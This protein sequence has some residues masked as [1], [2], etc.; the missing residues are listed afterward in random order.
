[1]KELLLLPAKGLGC[2]GAAVSVELNVPSLL[3]NVPLSPL[4][5][6]NEGARAIVGVE[7]D[8]AG[9][10]VGGALP[11]EME[12]K[13]EASDG[14]G[15]GA[16]TAGAAAASV[17]WF[18]ALIVL[19]LGLYAPASIAASLCTLF[20]RE[21][22]PVAIPPQSSCCLLINSAVA[23]AWFCRAAS[24]SRFLLALYLSHSHARVRVTCASAAARV[25]GNQ[26]QAE[27]IR[28]HQRQLTRLTSSYS[29]FCCATR[30]C[31][32]AA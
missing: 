9:G 27:A 16:G 21:T 22:T 30:C 26:R 19:V 25:R 10:E 23:N 1:M 18:A 15:V 29:S 4:T 28:D 32:S 17:F 3:L 11:V 6:C 7:G 12:A 13:D 8:C 20:T 2:E 5:S 31:R 24:M 14:G